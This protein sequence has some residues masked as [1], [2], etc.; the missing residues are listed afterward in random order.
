MLP[1]QHNGKDLAPERRSAVFGH[2]HRV[3][4]SWSRETGET[5]LGLAIVKAIVVEAHGGRVETQSEG[6][7]HESTFSAF[8]PREQMGVDLAGF[9]QVS[10]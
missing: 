7:E 9:Q 10:R 3:D 8:T 1:V 4:K 6:M 5:G 2:S